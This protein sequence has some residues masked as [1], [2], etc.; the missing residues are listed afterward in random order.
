MTALAAKAQLLE[1]AG[2]RYNFEREI[3]FNRQTK[4][5]FSVDFIEDNDEDT[6]EK[7]IQ[8]D[9]CEERWKF[10]FNSGPPPSVQ[11]ELEKVLG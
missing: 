7:R 5:V 4:K 6:L 2:Y 1:R 9:N 3:Y 11:R 8:E 10:Y